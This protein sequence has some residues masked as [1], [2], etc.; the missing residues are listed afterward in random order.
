M[1]EDFN[2]LVTIIDDDD[3]I[4]SGQYSEKTLTQRYYDNIDVVRSAQPQLP[5]DSPSV[6]LRNDKH[7]SV[8]NT[9]KVQKEADAKAEKERIEREER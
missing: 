5:P 3:L 4:T 8:K 2:D 9:A 6:L 7:K 1:A